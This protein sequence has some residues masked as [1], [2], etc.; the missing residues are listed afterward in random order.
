MSNLAPAARDRAPA[1]R[2]PARRRQFLLLSTFLLPGLAYL[3]L[4][5]IVPALFTI[6]LSLTHWNLKSGQP[7]V[8]IGMQNYLEILTDVTFLNSIGRSLV[9]TV[10]ATAIEL[11]LGIA[12]ALYIHR[13]FRGKGGTRAILVIPMVITPAVVGLIWYIL[14]HDS[15]GPLNAALAW[16]GLPAVGW[17][18]VPF[19]AFVSLIIADVWHHTPFIFL[20]VLSALQTIPDDLYE[21]AEIDGA[22]R[23]QMLHTITLPM[24]R[25]TILVAAILRSIEAF[26]IFAEPFVMTGGG[27]G[28]ATEM[29]SIHIYKAA[30]LFF[31]MGKAAAMIV[32][33]IMLIG[34]VYAIYL[35]SMKFD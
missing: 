28:T 27:P 3:V 1:L 8:F 19:N 18:T 12:I 15:I 35:R 5:R 7:P 6:Y 11:V 24:I 4:I 9:F 30:F 17:L 32:I 25:D 14:F 33:S 20:L 26:E 2:T 23:W 16:A 29:V 22:S 13:D 34:S 21:S 31:D 10:A